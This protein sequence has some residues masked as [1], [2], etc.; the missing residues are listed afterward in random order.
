MGGGL[1]AVV[2][3]GKS[4]NKERNRGNCETDA[5]ILQRSRSSQATGNKEDVTKARSVLTKPF[6]AVCSAANKIFRPVPLQK[7]RK[8]A[9]SHVILALSS[10]REVAD[11]VALRSFIQ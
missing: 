2:F 9:R 3:E 1:N 10:G 6:D 4:I 11:T 8:D 5:L 7:T